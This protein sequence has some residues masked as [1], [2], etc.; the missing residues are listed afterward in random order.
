MSYICKIKS[1]NGTEVSSK[2]RNKMGHKLT[3][4]SVR[5]SSCIIE[6]RYGANWGTL[7]FGLKNSRSP[8]KEIKLD[9]NAKS[10]NM[11]SV[12]DAFLKN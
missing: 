6:V 2:P 4:V 11:T 7:K 10:I 3:E 9:N 8:L 12:H 5:G 1:Q